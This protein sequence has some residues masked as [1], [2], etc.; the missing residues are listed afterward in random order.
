M[1]LH[2]VAQAFDEL[3]VHG[4]GWPGGGALSVE[5]QHRLERHTAQCPSC[6]RLVAWAREAII[7]SASA[8]AH[9]PRA[10][11]R[12]APDPSAQLPAAAAVSHP[13]NVP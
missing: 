9:Q 3:V 4:D 12:P 2:P 10:M 6:A 8:A 11:P 13:G 5:D 1:N 7:P